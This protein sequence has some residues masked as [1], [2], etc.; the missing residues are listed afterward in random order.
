[1]KGQKYRFKADVYID[2]LG[3]GQRLNVFGRGWTDGGGT[4]GFAWTFADG[5][6]TKRL[7]TEGLHNI[8][9]TVTIVSPTTIN[10]SEYD[11]PCSVRLETELIGFPYTMGSRVAID[12]VSLVNVADSSSG[13]SKQLSNLAPEME[14]SF[15]HSAFVY[16]AAGDK[17]ID[18]Y[19]EEI[20]TFTTKGYAFPNADGTA[21]QVLKTNGSGILTWQADATGAGGSAYSD[22]VVILG[23]HVPADS[24]LPIDDIA[25]LVGDSLQANNWEWLDG[26]DT[27]SL[28]NRIN[29]KLDKSDS[30]TGYA[31]VNDFTVGLATKANTSHSHAISDVTGLQDALNAKQATLISQQNV[32]SINNQTIVGSGN[33]SIATM[34]TATVLALV[35]D[36]IDTTSEAS[37]HTVAQIDAGIDSIQAID[38]APSVIQDSLTAK[39]NRSEYNPSGFDTTFVYVVT[40]SLAEDIAAIGDSNFVL[41]SETTNWDK[42]T[43][44]DFHNNVANEIKSLVN[45]SAP[46]ANDALLIEDA[47]DSWA[48]KY[49]LFSDLPISNIA[50]D[51]L[52][53]KANRT[54]LGTGAYATIANYAP[55]ANPTFTGAVTHSGI[56]IQTHTITTDST[57]AAALMYGGVFYVTE[58]QTITLPAVAT[59]MSATFITVGAVAVSI[60][61]NA[62][63]LMY[64]DGTA[65]SDGDKTTNT[66]TTGDIIVF[67][68]FSAV[69][70]YAASGS[71]DGDLWT[72]GN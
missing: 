30:A 35:E 2:S 1:V 8:D 68:Y 42:T 17:S 56:K 54:E 26:S 5:G 19:Q 48:K 31:T 52:D 47:D 60:D 49:S 50:Q 32:K 51:S 72:D 38:I 25:G 16:T 61:V 66:S 67:T 43:S 33:L 55:L 23:R 20:K 62:S 44:D 6:F 34:D 64:L 41:T 15:Y 12:N 13:L 3:Q 28:S 11:M 39:L 71:N 27:T 63:D 21:G 69:G 37:A 58:A 46:T 9:E 24:L 14:Y 7:I 65:L 4:Q 36:Y 59:G 10:G 57:I 18:Y 70:W 53:D 40:D 22:S 45:E 29:L